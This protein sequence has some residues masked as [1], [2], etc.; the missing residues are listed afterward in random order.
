MRQTQ[1]CGAVVKLGLRW[2]RLILEMFLTMLQAEAIAVHLQD[3]DMMCQ[4]V[5]KCACKTL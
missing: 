3:M 2:F 1:L 4:P 5:E